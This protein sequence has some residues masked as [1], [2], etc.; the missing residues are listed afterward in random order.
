MNKVVKV[1]PAFRAHQNTGLFRPKAHLKIVNCSLSL[2]ESTGTAHHH[3]CCSRCHRCGLVPLT[4]TSASTRWQSYACFVG[5]PSTSRC[6]RRIIPTTELSA[7]SPSLLTKL[8]SKSI[9]ATAS[10]TTPYQRIAHWAKTGRRHWPSRLRHRRP[11]FWSSESI[12]PPCT[13]LVP[14]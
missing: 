6:K 11:L 9:R 10:T 1:T 7:A 2:F 13:S 4:T 14:T 3:H 5:T 8:S 12:Q